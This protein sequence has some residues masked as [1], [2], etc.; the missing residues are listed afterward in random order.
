MALLTLVLAG[1]LGVSVMTALALGPI[2]RACDAPPPL[3][4]GRHISPHCGSDLVS[5]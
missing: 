5:A 2:L 4:A 3:D 1:W